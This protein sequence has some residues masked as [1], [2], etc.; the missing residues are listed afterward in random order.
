MMAET[1]TAACTVVE[2]AEGLDRIHAFWLDIDAGKGYV[3][4]I[5]YGAAWTAYFGAMSGRGIK[6][7][8]ADVSV[9]YMTNA[10]LRSPYLK[11]S[12]SHYRYLF[13]IVAAVREAVNA[14]RGFVVAAH[15]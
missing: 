4:I 1:T 11:E 14:E 2:G 3:T 13:K 6:E 8:F 5:C 10:L 9:E 15:E 7:F 12:K